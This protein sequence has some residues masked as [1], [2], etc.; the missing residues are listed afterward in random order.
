MMPIGVAVKDYEVG[1]V[2]LAVTTGE[3]V[4]QCGTDLQIDS[5]N[6][7]ILLYYSYNNLIYNIIT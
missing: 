7:M 4:A 5:Y 2:I 6:T 3:S 1:V